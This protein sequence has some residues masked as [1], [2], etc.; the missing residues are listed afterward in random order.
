MDQTKTK[1]IHP[2]VALPFFVG[3]VVSVALA[4]AK[5]RWQLDLSGYETTITV[6]VMGLVGYQ[7]AS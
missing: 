1:A 3:T 6:A 2:K 4:I 7:T 5:Q